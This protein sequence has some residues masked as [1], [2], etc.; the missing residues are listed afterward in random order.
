MMYVLAAVVCQSLSLCFIKFAALSAAGEVK[1]LTGWY[2]GSLLALGVQALFWQQALRRLPLSAAY[3]MMSLVFV[4][5]PIISFFIFGESISVLQA[6]GT[7]IIAAGT[8]LLVR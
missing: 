1:Y 5:I 3:P 6:A 4:V 8:I 2:F 7:G